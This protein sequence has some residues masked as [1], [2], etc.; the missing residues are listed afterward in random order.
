MESEL[1]TKMLRLNEQSER[2]RNGQERCY[3]MQR[4]T[5]LNRRNWN[6]GRLLWSRQSTYGTTCPINET[7]WR[8]SSYSLKLN[9]RIIAIYKEPMYGAAQSMFWT[10][11]LKMERSCHAGRRDRDEASTLAFPPSTQA[12]WD[13]YSILKLATSRRSITSSMMISS[14]P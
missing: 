10:P 1:I 11:L 13:V 5:G 6:S 14:L 2:R 4:S 3:C 8:R 7:D 9:F 12:L